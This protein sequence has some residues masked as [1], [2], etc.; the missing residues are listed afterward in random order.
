MTR[1]PI[2]P[3]Q[4]LG[5]HASAGNRTADHKGDRTAMFVGSYDDAHDAW[6]WIG[7]PSIQTYPAYALT[8]A[9]S[10]WVSPRP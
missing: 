3:D 7:D 10:A 4:V 6:P 2:T 5:R 9:N 1:W 8:D